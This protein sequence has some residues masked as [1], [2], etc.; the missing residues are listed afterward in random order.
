MILYVIR[1]FSVKKSEN[2]IYLKNSTS[3]LKTVIFG[4]TADDAD[5]E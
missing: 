3:V 2:V 4:N 1:L 5:P